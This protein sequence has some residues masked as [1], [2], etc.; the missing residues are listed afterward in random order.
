MNRV[1]SLVAVTMACSGTGCSKKVPA[2]VQPAL[3]TVRGDARKVAEAAAR[4]CGAQFASGQFYA[5]EKSCGS[6]VLPGQEVVPAF[7]SPAKGTALESDP[8]VLEV[9]TTCIAP[10]PSGGNVKESC[11]QTLGYLRNAFKPGD[12][13]SGNWDTSENSCKDSPSNCEM[14]EVPSRLAK[15]PSSVDLTVIRPMVGGPPGGTVS[16]KVTVAKK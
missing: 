11:G 7:P 4:I 16:V 9:E 13:R 6:K 3:E 12:F 10:L 2:G 14:V 8:N 1:V 15:E 5:T